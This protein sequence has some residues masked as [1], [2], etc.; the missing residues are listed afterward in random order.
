[1]RHLLPV[2]GADV[3]VGQL[4]VVVILVEQILQGLLLLVFAE[5]QEQSKAGAP[6]LDHRGGTTQPVYAVH[7]LRKE[8]EEEEQHLSVEA[9]GHRLVPQRHEEISSV[10]LVLQVGDHGVD[11]E[12]GRQVSLVPPVARCRW[13]RQ[14]ST[15]PGQCLHSPQLC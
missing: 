4:L 1:M 9:E 15:H 7:I 11:W 12:R 3:V 13:E 10:H 6:G 2:A 5:L 8:E 14:R